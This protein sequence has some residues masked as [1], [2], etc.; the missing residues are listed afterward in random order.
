M[1]SLPFPP[2]DPVAAA[3]VARRRER[4]Q[5]SAFFENRANWEHLQATRDWED[6]QRRQAEKDEAEARRRE[7]ERRAKD[8][9]DEAKRARQAA[10]HDRNN[11]ARI[12]LAKAQKRQT[13]AILAGVAMLAAVAWGGREH[14][15]AL[16]KQ[17]G[18][19]MNAG[20]SPE[21]IGALRD[22]VTHIVVGDDDQAI[23]QAWAAEHA[24]LQDALD[25]NMAEMRA[26]VEVANGGK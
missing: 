23:D 8:R 2:C 9:D 1:S 19:D 26:Q 12:A 10:Q 11:R 3:R 4:A 18:V 21:N 13:G 16:L 22:V 17:L 6:A 25:E 7:E 5:A 14:I 24:D 20:A 15:A